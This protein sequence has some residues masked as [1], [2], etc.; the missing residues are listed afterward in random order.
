M[1]DPKS[2]VT[3]RFYDTVSVS[4]G[5][6]SANASEDLV[7]ACVGLKANYPVIAWPQTALAATWDDVVYMVL[8]CITADELLIRVHNPTSG[9]ITPAAE[10]FSVVQL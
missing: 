8:G 4:P 10:D 9:A 5:E 1:A 2:A 3:L 7:V 6:V